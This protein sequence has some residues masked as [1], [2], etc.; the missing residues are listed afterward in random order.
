MSAGWKTSTVSDKRR[1]LAFLK[2]DRLYAAYAIGDLEPEL[3]AQCEWTGAHQEGA[4]RA[5]GLHYRGLSPD[6]LFLM[7]DPEGLR[8]LLMRGRTP[9]TAWI[10]F[11]AEHLPAVE[12]SFAWDGGPHPMWRMALQRRDIP[13]VETACRRLSAEDAASVSELAEHWELP[14][15]AADQIERGIFYGIFEDGRPAALAG[16]H[17]VS[18]R[19]GV[20]GVGNIFTRPDRRR[21][22]LG[23][24][25]VSAVLAELIRMGIR[26]I[27]LNV[28]RDNAPA[29]RLYESLGFA[30]HC[31]FFEGL[32][33]RRG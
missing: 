32:A 29:I 4:M 5:L 15:F 27:V 16:T 11:R 7:G 12:G 28:R 2:T 18:P 10:T 17:L 8:F 24:A 14:G 31:G 13:V 9:Q 26:D 30:R 1:L 33:S 21:R 22:G 23:R 3:F 6:A 20:A 25:T 19:Y